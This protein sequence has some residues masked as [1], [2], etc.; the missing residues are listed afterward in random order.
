MKKALIGNCPVCECMQTVCLS[1]ILE[2]PIDR[3]QKCSSCFTPLRVAP[4]RPALQWVIDFSCYLGT[5]AWITLGDGSGVTN[6]YALTAYIFWLTVIS[7]LIG[8]I[9]WKPILV[10]A[11]PKITSAESDILGEEIL[12]GS[13][14]TLQHVTKKQNQS[15]EATGD[16]VSR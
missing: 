10:V 6:F 8:R 16:N 1:A 12:A 4:A 14:D 5:L 7:K 9:F 11:G 2:I 15:C 13:S 3:T